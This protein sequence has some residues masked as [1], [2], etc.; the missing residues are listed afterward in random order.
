MTEVQKW[1]SKHY[2][3]ENP[4]LIKCNHCET[5]FSSC[6]QTQNLQ[7]HLYDKHEI[8]ELYEHPERDNILQSYKILKVAICNECETVFNLALNSVFTLIT[9]LKINHP[10]KCN[11]TYISRRSLSNM[12]NVQT[13]D[14]ARY[15][16]YKKV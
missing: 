16:G 3:I 4:D 12:D 15:E 2:T 11:L 8:T 6:D 14:N 7:H 9:H 5:V 10:A 13:D 1:I